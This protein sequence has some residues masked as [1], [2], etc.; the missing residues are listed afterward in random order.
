MGITCAFVRG[1]SCVTGEHGPR[2][3]PSQPHQATLRPAVC[4]PVMRERAPELVRVQIGKPD[5]GPSV[6]D[7]L[8]D[9]ACRE[10]TLP[11]QSHVSAARG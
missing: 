2:L 3:P 9:A 6:F 10:P 7:H 8:I 5:R 1:T 4:Q 11:S